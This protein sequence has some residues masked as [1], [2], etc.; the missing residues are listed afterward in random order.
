MHRRIKTLAISATVVAAV[1]SAL[2][3]AKYFN[4][5]LAFAVDNSHRLAAALPNLTNLSKYLDISQYRSYL[6]DIALIAF[7]L[8]LLLWRALFLGRPQD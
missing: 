8:L 3:L 4:T 6:K 2:V 5:G 7:L 1:L